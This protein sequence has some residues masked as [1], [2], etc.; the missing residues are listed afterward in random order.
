MK[1]A[2]LRILLFLLLSLFSL[3]SSVW[4]EPWHAEAVAPLR[5]GAVFPFTGKQARQGELARAGI[6]LALGDL[7][8]SFKP[9]IFYEDSQSG[10]KEA[11][12]A[13][14]KLQSLNQV[15]VVLTMGSPAAM[16]LLPLANRAHV[17]LMA[18]VVV[19]SYSVADDYGFR[20]MGTAQGFGRRI[21]EL[22]HE[23]GKQRVALISVE[24]DYGA[25]NVAT[26]GKE[27]E[28]AGLLVGRE[29]YLPGTSDFR[30]Q[31]LKL[32]AV[33]PDAV[34]LASWAIEAGVLLR[35]AREVR[36]ASSLFVCPSAC[37][38][39]DLI[40]SAGDA[41]DTTVVVASASRTTLERQRLLND[42]FNETPTSVVL[43][44]YDAL[45]LLQEAMKSCAGEDLRTSCLKTALGAIRDL[46]GSSYPLSFDQNGDLIDRYDLKMIRNAKFVPAKVDGRHIVAE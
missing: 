26:L 32:K 39:P 41:A 45:I 46:P 20:L 6:Q 24:D 25:G 22:L 18:M 31:L 34:V 12:A 42:R 29:S 14:S 23:T 3:G 43:R 35:Q 9:E 19:P 38:N 37:D 21:A 44:F 8:E 27:L 2:N 40:T 15:E 36:L 28:K 13:F 10:T 4:A 17:V 30:P 1:A 5:I 33:N 16:A 7:A 11:V